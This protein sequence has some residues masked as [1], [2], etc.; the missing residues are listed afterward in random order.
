MVDLCFVV[1][2]FLLRHFN[3]GNPI[4]N[5]SVISVKNR[6]LPRTTFRVDLPTQQL[7]LLVNRGRKRKQNKIHAP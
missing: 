5:L 6:E 7:D 2:L 4:C 3:K 1:V